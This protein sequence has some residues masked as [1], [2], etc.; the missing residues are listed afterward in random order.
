MFNSSKIFD[1]MCY[2]SILYHNF[3]EYKTA[4]TSKAC[5]YDIASITK[6]VWAV[7]LMLAS[8]TSFMS[9]EDPVAKYV[10]IKDKSLRIMDLLYYRCYFRIN[11]Y[12]QYG[13]YNKLLED[14]KKF[15]LLI[16]P[17]DNKARYSDVPAI[18][19]GEIL[20]TAFQTSSLQ[21]FCDNTFART[22][23]F[24]GFTYKP[25][26][27]NA[28]PSGA[29][30]KP[31]EVYDHKAKK[32][33][34]PMAHAG[35]FAS[36]RQLN[37]FGRSFLEKDSCKQIAKEVLENRENCLSDGY[38]VCS[39]GFFVFKNQS[40]TGIAEIDDNSFFTYGY[41]GCLLLVCPKYG[42]V[43]SFT[44]NC[45]INENIYSQSDISDAIKAFR[46]EVLMESLEKVGLKF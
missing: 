23:F 5:V 46:I 6:A 8:Q 32:F 7:R 31:G 42:F 29:E 2:E 18:L 22:K 35:L 43:F 28:V 19:I 26:K 41:T 33:H 1:N 24:S 34:V 44:S 12:S 17:K 20:K 39:K 9:L 38:H 27:E 37:M 40:F 10:N 14:I 3:R 16:S 11:R 30:L 36:C 25:E 4:S 45:R 15:D 13:T 21:N